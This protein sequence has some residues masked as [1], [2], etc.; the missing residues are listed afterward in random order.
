MVDRTVSA[1][2]HMLVLDEHVL[3]Y[4]ATGY[5]EA[6]LD[7]RGPHRRPGFHAGDQPPPGAS[8]A[9]PLVA[10]GRPGEWDPKERLADMDLDGVDA[11]VIYADPT[12]G[13]AFY[14]LS[15]EVGTAAMRAFNTAALEFAAVD[16]ARLLPVYLLPLYDVAL[17]VAELER[18]VGE[19]GRAVQLPLYPT[20][21]G[22]PPYWDE[23]YQPLWA[24]LEETRVPASLHVCP[25]RGRSLGKDPTPARGIFQVM[26]PILMSQPMV[27]L[28]LTGTFTRHPGLR[29]VLVEAGLGWIPY[30]LDRLDRVSDKSRWADRGMALDERPSHYWHHNMAATFEEDELGLELRDRIGIDNLLWAT[31]YPH[32]DSTWPDSRMVIDEQFAGLPEDEVDRLVCGN[33]ARLYGL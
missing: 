26:P 16:T 4:L 13:A 22:L 15:P 5:H 3:T 7:L 2:S 27:E 33:A 19:G 12:G 32:P 24:S 29:I 31:D 20:D 8:G 11:E 10:A 17:A 21:A 1:D 18:I 9:A 30:M 28:I 23:R 25:P 14:Q 6:Y